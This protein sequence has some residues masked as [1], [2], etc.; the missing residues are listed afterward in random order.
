MGFM[1]TA[2][3]TIA[4]A[5]GLFVYAAVLRFLDLEATKRANSRE[6]MISRFRLV[7]VNCAKC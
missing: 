5:V 2:A 3:F 7:L 4:A 1:P 6:P